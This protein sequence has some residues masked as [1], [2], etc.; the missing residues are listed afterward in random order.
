MVYVPSRYLRPTKPYTV[1]NNQIRRYAEYRN[2][3]TVRL[4]DEF[5]ARVEASSRHFAQNI[6]TSLE[7]NGLGVHPYEPIRDRVLRGRSSWVPAV[8]RYTAAQ[9]AVLLECCNMANADDR[10]LLLQKEWRERFA[11]AVVEGMASAYAQ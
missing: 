8:L 5:K 11:R 7:Q 10:E 4:G 3:P 1:R 9:N 2:H 6:L